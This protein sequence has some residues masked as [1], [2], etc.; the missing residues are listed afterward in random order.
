[1]ST[2]ATIIIANIELLLRTGA[3]LHFY[4]CYLIFLTL[5]W[6]KWLSDEALSTERSSNLLKVTWLVSSEVKI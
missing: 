5:K 6:V 4:M 2:I 3:I 1:M